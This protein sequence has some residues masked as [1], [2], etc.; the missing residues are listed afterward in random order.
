MPQVKD[1]YRGTTHYIHV[2]AELVRAAQYRGVNTYQDIAVIMGLPMSGS[3]MGAEIGHVLGEI[4]EDEVLAGRPMLSSVVVGV[5]KK[6]G[7]GF[8]SLAKDLGKLSDA[9]DQQAFWEKERDA[10]YDAWRRP[11][12]KQD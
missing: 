10:A 3:H 1:R 6:P 5:N 12:P 7:P 2:L 11:L 4:A 8:F 9:D